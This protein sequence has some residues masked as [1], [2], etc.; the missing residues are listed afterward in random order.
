M[1]QGHLKSV[2]MGQY[3]PNAG[4]SKHQI[5]KKTSRKKFEPDDFSFN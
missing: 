1:V 3:T 2:G 4:Y 5:E